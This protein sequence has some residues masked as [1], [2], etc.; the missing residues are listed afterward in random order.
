MRFPSALTSP[1]AAA[2]RLVHT[3]ASDDGDVLIRALRPGPGRRYVSVS[4]HGAGEAA[5]TLVACG[6]DPVLAYDL[7]DPVALHRLV[8]LKLTAARLLGREDYLAVMG[9]RPAS[10]LRRR[11]L[12]DQV[13]RGL[14]EPEASWW[15]P[16]RRWLLRGL[17][18]AD[19]VSAFFAAF[20]LAARALMPAD[21]YRAMLFDPEPEARVAAFRAHV[22]RA[23]LE[24]ALGAVGGRV[25]LF[26]PEMEWRASEYPKA[27]NR[28][29]LMY[30]ERLVQAGLADNPLFAHLVRDP[31]AA[32]PPALLPP[33]LRPGAFDGLRGAAAKLRVVP[34]TE[35]DFESAPAG[36][37]GAYLSNAIDYLEA[38][39]RARL[40]EALVARLGPG[41]PV[42]I[43]SNEAFDK[44]PEGAGLSLDV[45]ASREAQLIDRARIYARV[46]VWRAPGTPPSEPERAPPAG[47]RLRV[48]S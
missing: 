35:P 7:V 2:D 34:R 45:D 9:L 14:P 27:L 40:F 22:R 17:F 8:R 38:D 43:Y 44:V 33:H 6:A 37:H 31:D 10:R 1:W 21:A 20:L 30:L 48:V 23:G 19:R 25:N 42:L 36:L 24:A 12:A 5:M 46:Q 26:F 16:R 13:L 32:L 47:P 29:P 28:D 15:R 39:A 3:G 18:R 41:A 4:A 11:A